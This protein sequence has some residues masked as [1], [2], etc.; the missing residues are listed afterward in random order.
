MKNEFKQQE[1]DLYGEDKPDMLLLLN[2]KQ[3]LQ[4]TLRILT[5]EV[6]FL[7]KKNEKFLKELKQK[8]FYDAYKNQSEELMKLR[9][10]HALLI[11]MI[12][13]K[14][15]S[16]DPRSK[17]IRDVQSQSIGS[18]ISG[19][20]NKGRNFMNQLDKGTLPFRKM[21]TCQ[22]SQK[23]KTFNA[24]KLG[25]EESDE[26]PYE[27]LQSVQIQDIDQYLDAVFKNFVQPGRVAYVNFGKD[28]GKV[29][30]IVDIADSTRVLVENPQTGF[31]RVLYPLRRLTLTGLRVPGVLKG[32]RTGTV[33]TAAEKYQLSEK[34]AATAQSKKFTV[35][36]KRASLNDL[37][38]F[39]VMIN[40]KNRS[41]K[42]RHLAKKI[43][44]GSKAAA[45]GKGKGKK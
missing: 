20:E 31:P 38:R 30:V 16:I 22:T 37:D 3:N 12:Q 7:S 10:A 11:K 32:A 33:K 15:L 25:H 36:A 41:F 18:L 42:L 24:G 28:L 14:D 13:S 40:R 6:E 17:S 21:L 8:D 1:K 35:R 34:W 45:K 19:Q 43:S 27:A 23:N 4:N 44:G 9:E 29:V 39:K 5:E 2:E 26:E